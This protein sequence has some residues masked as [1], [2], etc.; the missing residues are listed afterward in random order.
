MIHSRVLFEEPDAICLIFVLDV[1]ANGGFVPLLA[2]LAEEG[3][4][5]LTR[6]LAG[7]VGVDLARHQGVALAWLGE[8][9]DPALL[10]RLEEA[11]R[12]L[13]LAVRDQSGLS[14]ESFDALTLLCAGSWDPAAIGRGFDRVVQLY[15]QMDRARQASLGALGFGTERAAALAALHTRNFL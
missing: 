5:P 10:D 12:R 11:L 9:E 15:T 2:L 4:D 7:R 1:I 13:H 8:A 14:E 6:A 3:P